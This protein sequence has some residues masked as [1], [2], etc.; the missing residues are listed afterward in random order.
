[1]FDETVKRK[2]T[3]SEKWSEE[4]IKNLTGVSY[5]EPFWVADMDFYPPPC[6]TDEI[7]KMLSSPSFGY[8]AF[9]RL[10]N[11]ISSWLEKKHSWRVDERDITVTSGVLFS[12]SLSILLF[13]E[14]GDKGMV[15]FPCYHPFI[16][17]LENAGRSVLPFA[18]GYEDGQ[19]YLEKEKFM[20]EIKN[21]DF[22]V[23]CSPHNPSGIV[24]SPSELEFILAECRKNGVKVFS[25]EI[26]ADLAHPGF[27]HYPANLINEKIGAECVTI[28][29]PSKTFNIAGEH[30][31]FII[32]SN[33]EMKEKYRRAQEV[34]HLSAP[35]FFSASLSERLYTEALEYNE[36][37]CRYLK[38]NYDALCSFVDENMNGIRVVKS[39]SSFII[40][41]DFSS[42]YERIRK[43]VEDNPSSFPPAPG[44]GI[45]SRFFGVRAAVAMN[46]GTWFGSEY[47]TFVRINYAT[48]REKLIA[49][50][51]RMKDALKSLYED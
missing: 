14:K 17:L 46:D 8:S 48:S 36:S 42:V 19:F 18:L 16:P 35:S 15:F 3:R 30:F 28:M 41:I 5:A 27:H 33:P 29:A 1:M 50:L 47:K 32:F 40:L 39:S 26:H 38:E 51:K 7:E 22:L 23:L 9:P 37:L 2:G 4:N 43:E 25:D 20:G 44:G 49:S 6:V 11:A 10:E 34:L 21:A 31:S 24:F 12:L 13:T 45:L